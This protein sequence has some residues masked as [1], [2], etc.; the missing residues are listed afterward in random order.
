M[1]HL[2]Q[3]RLE[4]DKGKKVEIKYEAKM[5]LNEAEQCQKHFFFCYCEA[6]EALPK[7]KAQYS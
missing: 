3:K 1:G 4:L 6:R 5:I 7:G 2:L